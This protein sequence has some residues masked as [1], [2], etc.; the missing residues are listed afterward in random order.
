MSRPTLVPSLWSRVAADLTE[1][2]LSE[3]E[4]A[5]VSLSIASDNEARLRRRLRPEI[6][7]RHA[8]VVGRVAELPWASDPTTAAGAALAMLVAAVDPGDVDGDAAWS[9][10]AVVKL[11]DVPEVGV[12]LSRDWFASVAGARY[13]E[14][15][16]SG[17]VEATAAYA[18]AAFEAVLGHERDAIL[19]GI[20]ASQRTALDEP[21]SNSVASF[22]R[23]ARLLQPLLERARRAPR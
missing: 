1:E 22:T 4:R 13:E 5:I 20:L 7:E 6:H 15:A 10:A 21:R 2:R 14:R 17:C 8:A 19:W 3:M 12:R 23:A 9:R 11:V 16:V 18:V